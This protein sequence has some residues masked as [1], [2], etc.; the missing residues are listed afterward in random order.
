MHETCVDFLNMTK[1]CAD[2]YIEESSMKKV[3]YKDNNTH[4]N[5]ENTVALRFIFF[6]DELI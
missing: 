1:K 6:E 2:S 3:N 4:V 5:E